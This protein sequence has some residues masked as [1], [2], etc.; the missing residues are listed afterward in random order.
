MKLI[1]LILIISTNAWAYP[2]HALDMTD[3]EY[4]RY[5]RPQLKSILQD[6]HTLLFLLNPEF[7]PYKSALS[8]TKKIIKHHLELRDNC[9]KH[10]VDQCVLDIKRLK[11]EL[12]ILN[13]STKDP[14]DLSKKEYLNLDE[15]LTAK[16][17]YTTYRNQLIKAQVTIDNII[18]KTVIKTPKSLYL[19]VLKHEVNLVINT[20]YNYITRSSDNRFKTEFNSYWTTFVVPVYKHILVEDKSSYFVNNINELNL[21]WNNLNVRLTKRNKKIS[22]QV[23]TLL[24]IMHNRWN[25]ILKVSLNPQKY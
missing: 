17:D 25:N 24:T 1:Y 20:F 15:K 18:L 23:K 8:D 6:T 7:K 4:R 16:Q 14:L 10:Q 21:R 19:K 3:Y 22:K 12:S 5:V 9:A 2:P 13:T 11:E